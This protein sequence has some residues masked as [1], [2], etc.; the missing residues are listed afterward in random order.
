MS[1]QTCLKALREYR[2]NDGNPYADLGR[3]PTIIVGSDRRV[4]LSA[5]DGRCFADYYQEFGLHAAS[6]TPGVDSDLCELARQHGC[7]WEWE[8]PGCAV[9]IEI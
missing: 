8:N 9:L 2:R 6:D 3:E 1:T 7:Y 5:E 4:L